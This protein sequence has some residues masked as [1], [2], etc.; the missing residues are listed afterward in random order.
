MEKGWSQEE[1][2]DRAG[3]HVTYLSSLERGRRNPTLNVITDIAR[4]LQLP[5]W[6]LLRSLSP[7]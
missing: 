1:L 6:K 5:T 4:A 7:E 3:L 2:A